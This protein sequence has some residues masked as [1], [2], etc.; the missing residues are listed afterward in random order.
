MK[1]I[2]LLLGVVVIL[3]GCSGITKNNNTGDFREIVSTS[4]DAVFPAVVYIRC[5]SEDFSRGKKQTLAVSGSGVIISPDGRVVTNWHVIDKAVE[6]RCQLNDGTEAYADIVG[7]DKDC[8]IALLQLRKIERELPFASIG[9][10]TALNEG[11]FVM[12]M[13]APF[14]LSRSVSIGI[15]S[16][17][18]RYL[19]EKGLYSLWLQTDASICPGNSGGPLVNTA[20]EVIGINTLGSNSGGGDLGFAV[21][22]E[23]VKLLID[24]LSEYGQANWSW[25]GLQ[26]QPLKDFDKNI[27]FEGEHGVIVS[28]TDLAS[29]AK[30]AGIK[31]QDRIVA[32]AGE[33]VTVLRPM[34]LPA[35]RK[36]IGLL[37]KD[38][39]TT[40][41]IEREGQRIDID[42]TPIA[43]GNTEGDELD[44]PRWDMTL[45]LINRFD[46]PDLYFHSKE[47]VF[48]NSIKSPG[49]AAKSG[50]QK[51]DIV[52]KIGNENVLDIN[53]IERIHKR[54][55]EEIDDNP[56]L[57]LSVLR[58]GIY[59]QVVLDI[60]R[61]YEKE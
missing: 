27:Y 52:V 60:S 21:P 10:S 40:F 9:D 58:N 50:L 34:H 47:G 7:S 6:I 49:N 30:M 11:D 45:K 37:P 41:T 5:L 17:T 8:D 42:V 48:V 39:P 12:A 2:I 20:G 13:G 38:V 57:V 32:I 19:E 54:S 15:V 51:N 55:L 35:I 46:N 44:C 59:R 33:P 43:K 16:C 53:D 22:S 1:K 36:L 24:R 31:V 14:G 18:E 25:T 61:D 29:P 26:L 4:K 28:G 3:N 56:R 23:M